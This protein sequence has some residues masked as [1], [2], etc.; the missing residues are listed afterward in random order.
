[1]Q[2]PPRLS[3]KRKLWRYCR[4]GMTERSSDGKRLGPK[5]LD[6]TGLGRLKDVS[7]KAFISALHTHRDHAFKR[8]YQQALA[9]TRT[10]TPARLTTRRKIP[11][12]FRAMWRGAVYQDNQG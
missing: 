5:R 2:T 3:S 10:A 6:H 4:L 8:A 9:R 12:G 7:R 11:A 1:M